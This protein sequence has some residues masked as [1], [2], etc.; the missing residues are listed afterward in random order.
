MIVGVLAVALAF[1][2]AIVATTAYALYYKD[3]QES[4]YTLANR[5]FMVMSG[6]VIFSIGLLIYSILVHNFQLNYVYSYSSMSLNKFYLFSTL[7]AGQEGTFLM[8]LT[9][10]SIFGFILMRVVGKKNPLVL[11]FLALVQSTLLLILLKKSPFAMLWHVHE[12]VPIGFMPADGAGLNPLLQNPWMVIH[13]PTLFLGYSS[14]VVPFVFAMAAMVT[15]DFQGWIKQARPWVV[16]NVMVLGTGIVMGGYW[17]YV[18]LGWGGYWGWDPVEN[19]SLVPWLFSLVLLHGMLI[20]G[21]RKSLVRSNFLWAGM[22]FLSM[23]WGSFLTRSGVLTDFSVHSFAPSG[24]T[25]YMLILQGLFTGLFVY[26]LINFMNYYRREGFELVPFGKGY[27]N[28]ETFIFF[29]M[30]VV[31]F[32]GLFTLFG[33][34]A[35]LYTQWFGTPASLSPDFYNT[36]VIPVALF[37]LVTVAV[38]PLLAWKTAELRNKNTLAMSAGAA[39]VLTLLAAVL[40]LAPMTSVGEHTPYYAIQGTTIPQFMVTVRDFMFDNLLTYSPYLIFFLASL[41]IIVNLKVAYLF[42]RNNAGKAGGY[43]AHAGLGLMVIGIL[44][45][46]VYDRS[47]KVMLPR[48]EFY[49]TESGYDIKFVNFL[50]MPDGKDRVKLEVKSRYGSTYEAYPQFYYSEYSKAYMVAPDVKVQFAKDVYISPISFTPARLA[51]QGELELG[52]TESVKY[53]DMQITFNKFL[54]QMGAGTQEITADLTFQVDENGYPKEHSVFPVLKAA[55][56]EMNS[57]EVEVP[58]TSYR[59][60]I[61]SVNASKG[62]LKLVISSPQSGNETAKDMLAIELSEKPFISVLWFGTIVFIIGSFLTLLIRA[63]ESR[64]D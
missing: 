5:S 18:T 39:F 32:I 35:P 38:A 24:L 25:L 52:K 43:V 56:G 10:G 8:W 60:K 41:V 11:F 48:G 7:W 34:S 9:Y 20:Q 15:R 28:R 26:A 51:N 23:L 33:T 12:E 4:L 45:S 44:T 17:A 55:N 57:S 62:T 36:M 13:P 6:G 14:T 64:K 21:K 19:A 61:A 63:K 29:G 58:G 40:G 42:L 46:S 47:E 53:K 1:I 3:R 50:D 27:I 31:M 37:M 49:Q 54:V 2:S 59:V 22:S 16:F 30:M